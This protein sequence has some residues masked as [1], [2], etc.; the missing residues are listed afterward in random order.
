MGK[1]GVMPNGKNNLLGASRPLFS[2]TLDSLSSPPSLFQLTHTH[3]P[4]LYIS[5]IT[6]TYTY[7]HIYTKWVFTLWT[8]SPLYLIHVERA[9]GSW[10][11][12]CSGRASWWISGSGWRNGP[13]ALILSYHEAKPTRADIQKTTVDRLASTE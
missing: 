6:L 3:S 12:E 5:H 11:S 13:I 9:F 8:S 10:K 2:S 7:D 4:P 1:A